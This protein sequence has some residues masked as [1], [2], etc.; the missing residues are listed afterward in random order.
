MLINVAS[1]SLAARRAELEE[2]WD[3]VKWLDYQQQLPATFVPRG[4]KIYAVRK[5]RI[6]VHLYLKLS[7]YNHKFLNWCL[8]ELLRNF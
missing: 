1:R 4:K 8:L 3:E 7:L 2:R 5:H 6:S